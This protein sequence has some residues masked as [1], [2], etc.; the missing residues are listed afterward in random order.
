VVEEKG[1]GMQGEDEEGNIYRFGSSKLLKSIADSYEG[2]H[3]FL[4][5]N[6]QLI[7]ALQLNDEIKPE[8]ITTI[9]NLQ[10]QQ[11]ECV[12]LS[13]DTKQKC[14]AVAK[15]LGIK[16]VFAEKLPTEKL[17]IITQLSNEKPTAMIGDGI[18]DAPSL[19]RAHIGISVSDGS[20]IAIQ[21]AQVILLNGNLN[22]LVQ[23]LKTSKATLSTI[24][25]NLFWAF[26]YNVVAIP[27]AAFGYLSPMIAAFSMAFSDVIVIGNSIWLRF[28]KI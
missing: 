15:Q 10:R 2:Y 22:L 11:I 18:N 3:L 8:S 25:Q 24:K 17:S 6:N 1:I 27:L 14:E 7:A 16:K 28:K 4:L 5:K 13:G 26:F 21:S 19:S 23:A 20:Q 12:L 9:K